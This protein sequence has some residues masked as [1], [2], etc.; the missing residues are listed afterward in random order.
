MK[1][2]LKFALLV[3]CITGAMSALAHDI[4]GDI[5]DLSEFTSDNAADAGILEAIKAILAEKAAGIKNKV[6]YNAEI[7]HNGKQVPVKY[8]RIGS[9]VHF[10][11]FG[12]D[13]GKKD[14][15]H[16]V[17]M[18]LPN[19]DKLYFVP[20]K[21]QLIKNLNKEPPA[22]KKCGTA[23]VVAQDITNM[24]TES[25]AASGKSIK[26]AQKIAD[27]VVECIKKNVPVH[28][29]GIECLEEGVK[30]DPEWYRAQLTEIAEKLR[31]QGKN[32][33][34]KGDKLVVKG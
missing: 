10:Y 14:L 15:T 6:S 27:D 4:Q 7:V 22:L 16:R 31:A 2:T 29:I 17:F 12:T 1:T 3:L 32:V 13:A 33:E 19:T 23:K 30:M 9:Q 20:K 11:V 28:E 26:E 25:A 34:I 24:L 21:C 5:G 8:F 18:N